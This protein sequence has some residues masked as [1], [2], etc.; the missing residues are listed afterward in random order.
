MHF[1][2]CCK[3]NFIYVDGKEGPDKKI[4]EN[5]LGDKKIASLSILGKALIQQGK[6][7]GADTTYGTA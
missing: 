7:H 1:L 6:L 2:S 3:F 5:I 4:M